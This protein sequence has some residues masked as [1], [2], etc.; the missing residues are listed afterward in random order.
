MSISPT[1]LVTC[2]IFI[3]T[4]AASGA[5]LPQTCCLWLRPAAARLPA[6]PGRR[7]CR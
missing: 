4:A 7:R 1:V 6:Q 2:L 5:G 3:A